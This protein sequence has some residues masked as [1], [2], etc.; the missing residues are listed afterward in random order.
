MSDKE[1]E[2]VELDL[3]YKTLAGIALY[4]HERNI[5]IND[6]ICQM[7]EEQIKNGGVDQWQ[8]QL[9]QNQPSVGSTPTP[10]TEN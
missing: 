10:A 8:S 5:T 4:A 3:D 1:Y 2:Q 9:T 7:L 6:A